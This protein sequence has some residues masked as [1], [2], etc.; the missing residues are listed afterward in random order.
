MTKPKTKAK[1]T[2][3]SVILA[4][5]RSEPDGAFKPLL[6]FGPQTVIQSCVQFLRDGGIAKLSSVLGQNARAQE[7]QQHSLIRA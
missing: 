7:L 6:A 2:T 5:G 4:A 3:C 1:S